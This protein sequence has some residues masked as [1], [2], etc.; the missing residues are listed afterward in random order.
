MLLNIQQITLLTWI[1][2]YGIKM[3]DFKGRLFWML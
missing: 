1:I 2:I 3:I